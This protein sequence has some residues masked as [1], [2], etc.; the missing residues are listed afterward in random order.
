MN[1]FVLWAGATALLAALMTVTRT[2]IVHAL[3]YLV[4][5]LLALAAM[6]FALGASFAG[7]LQI[8]VYAGAIVA[9]FVFVVMTVEAGPAIAAQERAR[10][11]G[12]WRGPALLVALL[13]VPLL[14]GLVPGTAAA[15]PVSAKAVGALLFGPWALAVELASFLLLAALLGA[16]HLARR[17]PED[18]Q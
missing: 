14:A 16:R 7:A 18:G 17:T 2:T 13:L 1:G 5:M 12:A 8:L 15:L 11:R 6:F 10:L 3:M 4:A 9:V